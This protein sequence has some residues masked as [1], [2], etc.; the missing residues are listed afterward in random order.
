M[1]ETKKLVTEAVLFVVWH[2]AIAVELIHVGIAVL[3]VGL[4]KEERIELNDGF[5]D[6]QSPL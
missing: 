2:W 1:G 4:S 3:H 5:N 6:P